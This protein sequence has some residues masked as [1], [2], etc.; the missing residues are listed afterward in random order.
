MLHFVSG[1]KYSPHPFVPSSGLGSA[2]SK[3]YPLEKDLFVAGSK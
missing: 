2:L 3:G 1:C